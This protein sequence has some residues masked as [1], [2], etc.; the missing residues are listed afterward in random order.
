MD[1]MLGLY[2]EMNSDGPISA[3]HIRETAQK[4]A[5]KGVV[6]PGPLFALLDD[7]VARTGRF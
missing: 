5:D 2:A 4:A 7:V 6:W 3:K 1:A